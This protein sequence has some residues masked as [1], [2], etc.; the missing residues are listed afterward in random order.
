[1]SQPNSFLSTFFP[2][3]SATQREQLVRY[4]HLLEHYNRKINLISRSDSSRIWENHVVPCLAGEICCPV[5]P[6][7]LV[8]DLGSG[9]GL[10]GILWKIVRPDLELHL[11]DSSRKK[12]AFMRRVIQQLQLV[13]I[14]VLTRRLVPGQ[15]NEDPAFQYDVILARAVASFSELGP[16]AGSFLRPGGFLLAWKGES[17]LDEI[18]DWT[19]GKPVEYQVFTAPPS[20][21]AYSWK[22]PDTRFIK[23]QFHPTGEAL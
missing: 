14:R 21:M 17:D 23:M 4:S 10:P 13:N 1:M 9:G 7:S 16:L 8:M 18:R 12:T 20:M 3:L 5:A 11:V 6:E 19:R 15:G 2:E 22:L